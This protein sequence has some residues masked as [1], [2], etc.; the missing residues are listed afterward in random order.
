MG[1]ENSQTSKND[2]PAKTRRGRQKGASTYN[3]KTLYDL[4]HRY[5]PTNMV[6]WG[7]VAEKFPI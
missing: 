5:K 6:L 2:E 3:K 7:T 1:K 4:V